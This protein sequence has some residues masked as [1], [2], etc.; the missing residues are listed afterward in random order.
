MP[1]PDYASMVKQLSLPQQSVIDAI[2]DLN[3][4]VCLHPKFITALQKIMNAITGRSRDLLIVVIGPAR[5]GKTTLLEAIA[6]MLDALATERGQKRGCFRFSVPREDHRG[7]F[8]WTDAIIEAYTKS[9][10]LL[11]FHKIEYGNIE[12]GAPTARSASR[13]VSV[14]QAGLWHSFVKNI[15]LEKL[16]TIVDEG[17]TIPV[18]LSQLQV[19]RAIHAL[20]YIVSQTEQPLV[21][22]GTSN[23]KRLVEHDVQLK[24]RTVV[25][26]LD[27][28]ADTPEDIEAF[29]I[30]L[31]EME[32]RL[33]SA[34]CVP[35]CLVAHAKEIRTALDGRPGLAVRV[36]T[37]ALSESGRRP[38]LTWNRYKR[39]LDD[40]EDKA[41]VDMKEERR[42]TAKRIVAAAEAA[43]SGRKE[44]EKKERSGRVGA[45]RNTNAPNHPFD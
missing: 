33:G 17:N 27:T 5:V 41:L 7:R 15:K 21:I 3:E 11:P 20:K 40:M 30:F 23:V 13:S 6:G 35:G 14:A 19:S 12:D 1:R 10:E 28:Y 39:H 8:N 43:T 36:A 25:I 9:D 2:A 45:T 26:A 24:L 42:I 22:G 34:H 44:P 4:W 31:E 29:T 16:V 37:N 18:T 38:P 32:K